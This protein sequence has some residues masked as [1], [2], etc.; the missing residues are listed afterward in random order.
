MNVQAMITNAY[1]LSGLLRVCIRSLDN[2]QP[3]QEG[4]D[5]ATAK[6]LNI[7]QQLAGDLID[8][9]ELMSR[10]DPT[11]TTVSE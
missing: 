1:D 4:D 11:A 2:E 9:L 8:G 7:A 3:A 6:A 5:V 10:E